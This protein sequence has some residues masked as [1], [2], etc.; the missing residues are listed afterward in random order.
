MKAN[1]NIP[2]LFVD[3]DV[4]AINKPAGILTIPD[5]YDPTA[6]H[7]RSVLEPEWGNLWIVHRLDKDTSGVILLARNKRAHR[8]LSLQFEN[9]Q[10]HKH[11][12]AIIV[13]SPP[14]QEIE[15]DIPLRINGDRQHRTIPAQLTG[16]TANTAVCVLERFEDFCL[17]DAS[18]RT[19]YTHQI[20]AHLAAIGFPILADVLYG[21]NLAISPSPIQR[22]ALHSRTIQYTHPSIASPI[23]QTAPYISGFAEALEIIRGK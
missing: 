15:I 12:H 5:G 23:E 14:W 21:K 17:V 3:D 10:I 11:Y 18:P 16:K 2:S 4:L 9:R 7:L 8:H 13:G 20:R 19:G 1:E 6:P 22:V